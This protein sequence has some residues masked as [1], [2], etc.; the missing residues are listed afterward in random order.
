MSETITVVGNI[1]EPEF[2]VT[3]DGLQILNFRIGSNERR[4][5][6]SEEKWVE[7]PTS[8]YGVSV[9]RGLAEH[10]RRSF[11][12]GDRVVVSGRLRIREWE[13]ETKKGIAA[14]IEADALGHDL[15][16]G[17]TTF[18][19]DSG[20]ARPA[21]AEAPSDPWTVGGSAEPAGISA[22]P[23]TGPGAHEDGDATDGATAEEP[24]P[25]E[26][27]DGRELAS[28]TSPF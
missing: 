9:F 18:H 14:E 12:K 11:R 4:F 26:R 21:V 13:T 22:W 20:P 5:D 7:G 28:A 3:A 25:A 16:W 10:G 8:W 19:R 23:T 2:K 27:V 15:R 1:T 6:K 24:D 17:T